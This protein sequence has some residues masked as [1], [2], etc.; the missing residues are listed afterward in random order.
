MSK[1]QYV[2]DWMGKLMEMG[3]NPCFYIEVTCGDKRFWFKLTTDCIVREAT[4]MEFRLT[5]KG[6][7]LLGLDE[8]QTPVDSRAFNLERA[9]AGEKVVTGDGKDVTILC[10]NR[11]GDYPIVVLIHEESAKKDEVGTYCP[12]GRYF[13]DR[14]SDYDLFMAEPAPQPAWWEKYE[15]DG[16]PKKGVLCL[17]S[18]CHPEEELLAMS[19]RGDSLTDLVALKV[20]GRDNGMF[21]TGI[22]WPYAIPFPVSELPCIEGTPY[23]GN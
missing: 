6:R 21:Y 19:L 1:Y 13:S 20:Y 4:N 7:K 11:K 18:M 23:T 14:E 22:R 9:K 2:L 12:D 8:P 3:R 16:W 10:Y 17:V 15:R 5:P